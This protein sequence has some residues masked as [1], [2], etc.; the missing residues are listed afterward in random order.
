MSIYAKEKLDSANAEH[1]ELLDVLGQFLG[2][3]GHRVEANQF[4]DAFTRLRSGPA[5]FEAKSVT[6]DNELAQIRHGLSQLYEYRYRH[7]LKGATLWL[8]LSREPRE[9]WVVNYLESDRGVHILWLESGALAGS[10]YRE[11]PGEW[12]R[13]AATI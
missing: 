5:I 4:V 6:D 10:K 8:V 1:A 9:S 2:A 12:I 11:A 7:D 13:G 3:T